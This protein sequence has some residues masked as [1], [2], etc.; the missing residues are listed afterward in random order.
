MNG[1]VNFNKFEKG[2]V[3][4]IVAL[5]L[6]ALIAMAALIVD[7]AIIMSHRRTAQAAADSAALAGAEFLCPNVIEDLGSIAAAKNAADAEARFYVTEN[8]AEVVDINFPTEHENTIHVEATVESASFFARIL[9]QSI[10][11]ANAMAEASC[12]PL[13][14]GSGTLPIV[15]PCLEPDEGDTNICKIEY[16]DEDH[17]DLWNMEQGNFSIIHDSEAQLPYCEDPNIDCTN[18]VAMGDKGWIS[19]DGSDN[20]NNMTGWISGSLLPPE[21]APGFWLSSLQGGSVSW[22]GDVKPYEGKD[23]IIP[24]YDS[25]CG[26]S[27]PSVECPGLFLTGDDDHLCRTGKQPSF[28]I[29]GFGLFKVT[30][31]QDKQ[32]DDCPYR[33]YLAEEEGFADFVGNNK[34]KTIEGYFI[35]GTFP[36]GGGEGIDLGLY[37]VHL[38]R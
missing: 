23:F 24:I 32:K 34:I 9:N 28:R 26:K 25:H 11:S 18:V 29:I 2:Q 8:Y 15:Y 17:D 19:L 37:V 20:K 31:V 13:R 36:T 16:Y 14:T 33:K 3:I 12:T 4:I 6:V 5:G 38:R 1:R 35:G 10:L 7:G 30:C 21:I 27:K 22:F